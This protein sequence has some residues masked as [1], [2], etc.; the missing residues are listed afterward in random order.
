MAPIPRP[1]RNC[2]G[3]NELELPRATESTPRCN[4][5]T[6]GLATLCGP[7]AEEQDERQRRL[8][9]PR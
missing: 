8:I 2:L 1:S 9:T 4:P 3:N 6:G 7:A 5:A